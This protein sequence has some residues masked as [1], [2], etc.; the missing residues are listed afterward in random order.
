MRITLSTLLIAFVGAAI[1]V[2]PG[3]N[4]IKNLVTF[5]DSYTDAS[6]TGDGGVAWPTYAAG[7][8]NFT[9]FPFAK[10][11]ATCSNNL[12][13]A[14]FLSVAEGQIPAYVSQK[15]SGEIN[16]PPEETIYTIWIGTNDLGANNILSGQQA[17][18]VTV[19][20]TT[21]CAVNW[22]KTLYDTGAR[23][24]LFQNMIPLQKVPMYQPNAYPNR[25]WTAARNT[26]AWSLEMAELV[27]AG[28]TMARLMLK[29]LTP[30]LPGAHV[31]LFDSYALFSDIIVHPGNY[32]N[33]TAPLN[34]TDAINACVFDVDEPTNG[35]SFCTT[36]TGTDKDSFLWWDEIHPSEQ[37]DR[38]V[39]REITD[40][41]KR[42]SDKWST[43]FS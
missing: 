33:G 1:A 42:K 9:L 17:P 36:A 43:W 32:L 2:G 4:Q 13:F 34:V 6:Q 5:G 14:P 21:T 31:G 35:P 12:T 15:N 10:A 41:I 27:N 26:T 38:V 25:Y 24:F 23:N 11:G 18:G 16:V 7:Y 29:E 37:A 20:D 39:A 30:T 19:V 8:G 3:P 28:N 40:A 22:A